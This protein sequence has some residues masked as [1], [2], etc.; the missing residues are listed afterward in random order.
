MYENWMF[1]P[2]H[3]VQRMVQAQGGIF[4]DET[5]HAP[6]SFNSTAANS[7]MRSGKHLGWL[8]TQVLHSPQR[9]I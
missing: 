6:R 7:P 8:S 9:C 1:T 5:I 4:K 3:V 2:M